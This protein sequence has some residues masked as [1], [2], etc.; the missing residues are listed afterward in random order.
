[1]KVRHNRMRV[2]RLLTVWL[3]ECL[4]G[5]GQQIADAVDCRYWRQV[6]RARPDMWEPC[7]ADTCT[8]G[9]T[10]WTGS[11]QQRRASV[12]CDS[13]KLKWVQLFTLETEV[14]M[15]QTACNQ[16][17]NDHKTNH[18]QTFCVIYLQ[19]NIADYD[20]YFCRVT[21]QLAGVNIQSSVG[22]FTM[23][24]QSLT[25]AEP[26]G[27]LLLLHNFCQIIWILCLFDFMCNFLFLTYFLIGYYFTCL[28][29]LCVL[30]HFEAGLNDGFCVF[31][32]FLW[33]ACN[34]HVVI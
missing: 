23:S 3:G 24:C 6:C 5:H 8:L 29:W 19:N 21:N 11:G 12:E 22:M 28:I 32:F 26:F 18:W 34:C 9:C 10:A 13:L 2:L 30:Y 31:M 1:M 16:E 20:V 15:G 7:C 27:F 33:L 14:H 17:I 4:A 25:N